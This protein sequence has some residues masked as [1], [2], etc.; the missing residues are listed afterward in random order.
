M[1]FLAVLLITVF[2]TGVSF[3]SSGQNAVSDF[4]DREVESACVFL[5]QLK[6]VLDCYTLQTKSAC[7]REFKNLNLNESEE[8][9]EVDFT[10]EMNKAIAKSHS[11]LQSFGYFLSC[12]NEPSQ[13]DTSL[14]C[15]PES[16]KDTFYQILI[17]E[18]ARLCS[19]NLECYTQETQTECQERQNK[20]LDCNVKTVAVA[21]EKFC[22]DWIPADQE[23]SGPPP[24]K[25]K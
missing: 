25:E 19:L 16:H 9:A 24:A 12:Y 5:K 1:K 6:R 18:K 17:G 4:N 20:E 23:N 7:L 11:L 10:M 3:K 14:N 22:S 2:G 8:N 15:F 21:R 13:E